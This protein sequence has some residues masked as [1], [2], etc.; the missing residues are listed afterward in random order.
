MA[1]KQFIEGFSYKAP[2]EGAPDF[3]KG[4]ISLNVAR[5]TEWFET[6]K[7][8]NPEEAWINIDI[9]ESKGGNLYG[10]LNTYKK[11]GM[12]EKPAALNDDIPA[13]DLPF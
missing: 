2:R 13:D 12:T 6:W 4:A 7:Q 11:S 5:F 8:N 3:V 9:K 1:D 10:E